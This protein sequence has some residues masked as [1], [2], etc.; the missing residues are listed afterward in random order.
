M[1][2]RD[3]RLKTKFM[4]GS[5]FPMIIVVFLGTTG[6]MTLRYLN[7]GIDAMNRI[8]KTD[9]DVA[10]IERDLAAMESEL[11]SYLFTGQENRLKSYESIGKTIASELADLK[12]RI[13]NKPENAKALTGA[14]QSLRNRRTH[15][16]EKVI[17][18]R[19]SISDLKTISELYVST[20]VGEAKEDLDN[21]RTA[22]AL[23]CKTSDHLAAEQAKRGSYYAGLMETLVIYGVSA[24]ILL[25]LGVAYWLGMKVANPLENAV[26]LA[27]A[28]SR[29][30]LTRQLTVG[31]KDE[32][33]RLEASLNAMV[34]Y[35]REQIRQ[36]LEVVHILSSA[37]TELSTTVAQVAQSTANTSAA[38]TETNTTVEQVKQAARLAT[39]KS[40]KVAEAANKAV[41]TSVAGKTA[42]D[43]TSQQMRMIKDQMESIGDTVVRLSEHSRAI[44][45]II[46]TVKDLSDQSNLL[47]VNA[48][49]EAA[50][51]GEHG[52]G[53]AVV[54]HEIKALA[55]QSRE[56]ADQVRSILAD[57]NKWVSA[58]VMATE[59]GNKA[60][61][62]GV[63]QAGLAGNSIQELAD[64]VA[65]SAQSA[66]VIQT[67]SEQQTIGVQQVASAMANIVQAMQQN[68]EGS[69]QIEKAA[70]QL[71]EL[72]SRLE[73]LVDHYKH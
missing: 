47:A 35:L 56:A 23:L 63:L 45:E 21:V 28:I 13:G 9:T 73:A 38:V 65:A 4:L 7:G 44:E 70:G 53:F 24:A 30:D 12:K 40:R 2:F 72:G 27:E 67:T 43:D 1:K 33:G 17:E 57:T 20:S 31:G 49:I 3:I 51:A 62:A 55:D 10:Q 22:L 18:R 46:S 11:L 61:E 42:T 66:C 41:Q 68:Q 26:I 15:M 48:S 16:A 8:T 52:K 59:Q 64:S 69:A 58:T 71:G 19:K 14:E 25:S 32:V 36:M 6:I 54:A 34:D 37:A 60:V 5:V 29:G 39:E 50:R